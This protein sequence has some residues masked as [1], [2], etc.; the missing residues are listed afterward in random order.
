MKRVFVI[1][2]DSFGIGALPDAANYG[3]QGSDTL[4]ACFASGKLSV[5]QMQRLGLFNIQ[6]VQVG[7]R[8]QNPAGAFGRMAERSAGK[9][10]TTGH[11]E[12]MGLVSEKPMPTYPDGFPQRIIEQ[13][14]QRTGRGI[15]CNRPY[16][17]TQVIRDYGEQHLQT[18]DLIVYTS[19][20]SVL[21]IAAHEQKVPLEQLYEYC[22]IARSIM[23]G[24][25]AVGR[26][27]ARP[28]VGEDAEHFTRTANRRDFS[29]LP[30]QDTLLDC[31]QQAGLQTIGVGKIS[32]IFAGKGISQKIVTHSNDEGMQRTLE[33]CS[34]DF[35]GLCFVNLVEFDMLYGHRNDSVG[36]AQAL[37]RFDSQL[38]QLLGLLREED[39]LFIT[40]DHGCDPSYTK[41]TD[42]TREYVPYLICGKGV[43]P[44]VDLGT[45]L[46]FGTIAQT[47]C[48][49]L[50]VDAS[51]L[52]GKSVWNEIKA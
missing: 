33:L 30:P 18:G 12:L 50:D 17:G 31:L 15:L 44:G 2:L 8:C 32:D 39:L 9:D 28:F 22:Q 6:G 51:S 11:W 37:S 46:C 7:Q 52:D 21:Q 40:A 29:L 36:Y 34:S 43:K 24:E 4:A 47:I 26:I 10:T 3:D 25:D 23:Q 13:L 45:R 16:S 1:V 38:A 35:E 42:H 41:T 49:Y 19:A 14:A 20:D 48:E 27:I 5:P